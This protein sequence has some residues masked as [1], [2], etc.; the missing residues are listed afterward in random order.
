MDR[1]RWCH[2]EELYNSVVERSPAERAALLAK[3]DPEIRA[4]VEILLAEPSG[5]ALLDQHAAD[6]FGESTLTQLATGERLGPYEII[7][8]IGAGGMGE[9]WRARDT[10]LKRDVAIKLLPAALA[11]DPD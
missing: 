11:H 5:G 7:S 9:V 8:P 1:E 2:I 6:L 10:R 3:A 4:E